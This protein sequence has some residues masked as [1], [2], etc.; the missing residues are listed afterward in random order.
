[1]LFSDASYLRPFLPT[2]TLNQDNVPVTQSEMRERR[3][4]ISTVKK[5]FYRPQIDTLVELLGDLSG[6]ERKQRFEALQVETLGR[7]SLANQW[8]Q[9]ERSGGWSQL[10]TP[11]NGSKERQSRSR[12]PSAHY[13]QQGTFKTPP[14]HHPLPGAFP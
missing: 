6:S 11:I 14:L 7:M 12:S 3:I 9:W 2:T 5:V 10:Q 4:D 1:M 8:E 13:Q